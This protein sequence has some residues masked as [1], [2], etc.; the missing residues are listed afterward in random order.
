MV[1]VVLVSPGGARA[2][3]GRVGP[4]QRHEPPLIFNLED[5]AGEGA[6]LPRGGAQYQAVLPEVRQ[7]LADIL[8]DVAG[9]NVSRADYTQDPSVIPCCDPAQAACRCRSEEPTLPPG[10]VSRN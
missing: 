7:A 1:L 3:D 5:D 10:G 2:C 8:H 6:P 4:E 9:D